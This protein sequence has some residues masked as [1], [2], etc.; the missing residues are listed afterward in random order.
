MNIYQSYL[1]YIFCK[2]IKGK[3]IMSLLNLVLG[4]VKNFVGKRKN[5]LVTSIYSLFPLNAFK[6][7]LCQGGQKSGFR[8]NELNSKLSFCLNPFPNKSGF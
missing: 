8:G 7:P 3:L 2:V 1:G 6:R 5:M 4:R